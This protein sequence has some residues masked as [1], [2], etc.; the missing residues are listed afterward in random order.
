MEQPKNI[1]DHLGVI[2][3][4]RRMI[5]LS[6]FSVSLVT[7]G[8]SL[9]L[10][11][12]YRARAVVYPPRKSQDMLG[13]SALL[14]GNLPMG[15]LGM[16]EGPVSATDFVPVLQ[17]EH[18]AEGVANRFNLARR[19]EPETREQLLQMIADRLE[20]ELSR[21][22]FLTV[23]YEDETPE[24][25]AE[26]TGAFVEELDRALQKRARETARRSREYWEAR[27]LEAEEEMKTAELAYNRFQKEHM[28]IDLE[29]QAK[30]QIE[31]A[32]KM[33]GILAELIV[34]RGV[35]SR[36]MKSRHPKLRELDLKIAGVRESLDE[37]LMGRPS[38]ATNPEGAG[39]RL[40]E[41]FIPFRQVP[42]LALK[43]L[44][45]MRDVEIQNAI[46]QFVRQES[47]KARFEEEKESAV[48]IVLD[49]AVPPDTRS[50][51]RRSLLVAVAGGLSLT[52]SVL[53][54]F[55]F[56][57]LQGLEGDN[58]IKLDAILTDFRRKRE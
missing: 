4:W 15:L 19:Y 57:A 25:A 31:S 40:P 55:L 8:I 30:A 46:Y 21:E 50:R 39:H 14:G 32:G 26:I 52:L 16:G 33:V 11:V 12:A 38:A 20:V 56:E 51:P 35:A 13:L 23:S 28:A 54:A 27:L 24:L 29:T 41:F 44:Q 22:Q 47:E 43:A 17:S 45:L 37:I 34:E 1:L 18:V 5:L 7:A 2:V 10:P 3:R 9:V 6:V 36:L 42:E 49:K 58:R 53:L 48:V